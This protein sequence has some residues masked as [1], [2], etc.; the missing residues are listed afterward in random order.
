MTTFDWQDGIVGVILLVA[1][2]YLARRARQTFSRTRGGECGS[3]G[4]GTCSSQRA[5][6]TLV[7][8]KPPTP[9]AAD[10]RPRR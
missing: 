5:P 8:L 6:T 3:G 1:A 9:D 2:L 10:D 4:C 7:E